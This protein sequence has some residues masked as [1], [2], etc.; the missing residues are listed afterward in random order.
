MSHLWK[1]YPQNLSLRSRRMLHARFQPSIHA[2]TTSF[3]SVKGFAHIFFLFFFF[4]KTSL[5]CF[6][7]L[8]RSSDCGG[9]F[10]FD[11]PLRSP[12]E[13][14]NRAHGT[15]PLDKVHHDK[16]GR[17]VTHITLRFSQSLGEAGPL[18]QRVLKLPLL[19]WWLHNFALRKSTEGAM[20]VVIFDLSASCSPDN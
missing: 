2:G 4:A 12:R 17:I 10:H 11:S 15:F 14:I 7:H 9:G 6:F 8:R 20:Q 3:T 1:V 19:I 13:P 18:S 16:A 5:F